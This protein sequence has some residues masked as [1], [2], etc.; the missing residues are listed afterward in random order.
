M[1]GLFLIQIIMALIKLGSLVTRISG[2]IGGQTFGTSASG[3]YIRNTGTPRKAITLLQRS[4]MSLMATTAQSWRSLTQQQR[5]TF[6]AASPEY[7]YLNRVGDTKNYSGY[8]IYTML[9]N[10]VINM[11][12]QDPPILIPTPLPRFSFTPFT[13]FEVSDGPHDLTFTGNGAQAGVSYR[14]FV[15]QANSKGI[16]TGY[17]NYFYMDSGE[18]NEVGTVAKNF[19]DQYRAKWGSVPLNSK[20]YFRV[21]AIHKSTGQI[22]KGIADGSHIW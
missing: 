19:A 15:T 4:K 12:A 6:I 22:L 3:S 16:T 7:T 14:I 17:K 21:D 20:L 8:A 9:R 13:F 2:K 11:G 1:A 5:D 10:N 18:R